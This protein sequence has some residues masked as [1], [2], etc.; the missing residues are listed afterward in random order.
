MKALAWLD[1]FAVAPAGDQEAALAQFE[2]ESDGGLPGLRQAEGE[3]TWP[4]DAT[5]RFFDHDC[6]QENSLTSRVASSGGLEVA[7]ACRSDF[8]EDDEQFFVKHR[9]LL[10]QDVKLCARWEKALYGK[11]IECNDFD[12]FAR[13]VNSLH[14]GLRDAD[15]DRILRFTVAKGRK[16]WRERFNYDAGSYFSAM[17][18]GLKELEG[19]KAEWKVERLGNASLPDPLFDYEAFFAKEK[20]L[21]NDKKNKVRPNSSLSRIALQ[22][23]FDVA[24]VQ[25]SKDKE[26][27]LAKTQLLWSYKPGLSMVADHAACWRRER[28]AAQRSRAAW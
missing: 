21:R 14:A 25:V 1:A 13:V 16:E 10:E 5:V 24:L 17:Y 19:S 6:D 15:G 22:I 12:G 20:E 9:R 28:S 7:R 2:W 23:K 11:P 8:T 3:A 26:T 27:V 4:A 18:R